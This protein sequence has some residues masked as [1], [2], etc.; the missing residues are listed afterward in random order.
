MGRK[1]SRFLRGGTLAYIRNFESFMLPL[2]D[3]IIG[4]SPSI[5]VDLAHWPQVCAGLIRRGVCR[6]IHISDIHHIKGRPLL[7]GLF[8]FGKNEFAKDESGSEFEVCRLIMNLVPTNG[9]C[10]SLT[11]DT[12][13]LPS[14]IG[15]SSIVL[16]DHQLLVTSSED[17]RSVFLLP[18]PNTTLVVALHGIWKGDTT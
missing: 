6:P 13:T 3:Q 18:I 8:A 4:K 5:M 9:C 12:S 16:E 17:I 15:M 11:G 10:R 14:V 2:E 7:N 1:Q